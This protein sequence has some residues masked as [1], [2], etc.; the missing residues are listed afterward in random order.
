MRPR[1]DQTLPISESGAL[2]MAYFVTGATGFIGRFLVQELM[3][4]REGEI[5]ALCREGSRDRLERLIEEWT[6]NGGDG[7]RVTPVIGDLG[8]AD[9]GLSHQ[10]ITAHAGDIEPFFPLAAIY[11]MTASDE[12]NETMNV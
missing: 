7:S 2:T 6:A 8:E 1:V 9:L 3:D 4:N 12:M 5:F 10:W 11:D